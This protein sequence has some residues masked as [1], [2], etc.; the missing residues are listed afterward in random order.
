MRLSLALGSLATL[1]AGCMIFESLREQEQPFAFPHAVHAEEGLGCVDC[2]AAVA[3]SDDP[4]FPVK[5]QCML[6]HADMDEEQ[7][8]ERRAEALFDGDAYRRTGRTKLAAEIVFPHDLHANGAYDCHVCHTGIEQSTYVGTLPRVSMADCM[9]CHAEARAPNECA[10]CHSEID[11]DW[12]PPSHA[13]L[14][15]QRHGQVFRAGSSALV[16]N[17]SLC[18]TAESS[19]TQCHLETPPQSHNNFFRLRGHGLAAQM[20]RQSCA[21]CH[22]PDSCQ[23]CHMEVL[24]T[25]HRGQFGGTLS[26]HCLGCHFPL[27]AN[28]CITCHK[29][30][31]SH[32]MATPLPSDPAHSPGLNCRQCHGVTAPLPHVDKGDECIVCHR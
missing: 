26:T 9:D 17:C 8:P 3:E 1:L 11:R 32:L 20:D 27:Q 12:M 18:H 15:E 23:R 30:T 13:E 22:R 6:C 2:H 7:P 29:E 14:W 31:P 4:G 16:D 24:P 25:S 19:C 10:T 5:V 28:G 21:T